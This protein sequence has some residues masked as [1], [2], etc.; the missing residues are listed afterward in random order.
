MMTARR[1]ANFMFQGK[2]HAALQ[3][4]SDKGKGSVLH[5]DSP[6]S[7]KDSEHCTVKDVLKSKHPPGLP[8][9]DPDVVI[10]EVPPDVY[11]VVFDS[12]DASLIRS[13]S[14]RTR[15]AAGL[16]A[17]A[18]RK[19]MHGGGFAPLL[20]LHPR[21]YV[22]LWHSLPSVCALSLLTVGASPPCSQLCL[23]IHAVESSDCLSVLSWV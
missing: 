13:I 20:S 22:T 15:G 11:S 21:P 4:L 5:L 14:L 18:W 23:L 1:F 8:A 9:A 19:P 3:L 6:I 7:T 16:D 12:I 17:Y 2:T 10:P